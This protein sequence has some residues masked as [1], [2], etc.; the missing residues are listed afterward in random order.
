MNDD[1]FGT[2]ISNIL[3]FL[4]PDGLILRS[5]MRAV[6]PLS[7]HRAWIVDVR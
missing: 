4:H 3:G 5:Q 1:P 6:P 7:R 2:E